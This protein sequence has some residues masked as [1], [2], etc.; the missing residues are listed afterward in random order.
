V[1]RPDFAFTEY[2]HLSRVSCLYE[3]FVVRGYMYYVVLVDDDCNN[4]NI[5]WFVQVFR[6]LYCIVKYVVSVANF[7]P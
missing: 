7:V 5:K 1:K 2:G 4:N 6:V 3:Y